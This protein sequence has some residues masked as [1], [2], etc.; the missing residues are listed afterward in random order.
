M[1]PGGSMP[2]SQGLSNNP[3]S[4]AES[5]QFPALIPISSRS[6]LILSS[7]LRLSLPKGLFPVDLPVK[8][9]KALLPYSILA[10]WSAHNNNNNNNNKIIIIIIIIIIIVI[11]YFFSTKHYISSITKKFFSAKILY[12]LHLPLWDW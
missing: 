4:W 8:I 1:E 12:P 9:L 3:V 10:T 11:E 7:H 5:T 2:H 6:I